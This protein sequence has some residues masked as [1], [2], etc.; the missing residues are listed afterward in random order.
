MITFI[1]TTFITT[2]RT[3]QTH[4]AG[5]HTRTGTSMLP[6]PT[7]IVI[8]PTFTTGIRTEHA[9]GSRS[10]IPHRVLR[11]LTWRRHSHEAHTRRLADRHRTGRSRRKSDVELRLDGAS[12]V[13]SAREDEPTEGV[14]GAAVE[15][16]PAIA[17]GDEREAIKPP[18]L[19]RPQNP[20]ATVVSNQGIDAGRIP[21]FVVSRE[22]QSAIA[23]VLEHNSKRL[24]VVGLALNLTRDDS[25]ILDML[26]NGAA[27]P[28]CPNSQAGAAPQ[29]Q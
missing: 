15:A 2:T 5:S 29:E 11:W 3:S 27:R 24:A 18:V 21:R 9:V 28:F 23:H 1:G 20:L 25:D 19:T 16:S 4:P 17:A 12:L 10:G 26:G 6:R 13:I 22:G 7:V 8:S 14:A